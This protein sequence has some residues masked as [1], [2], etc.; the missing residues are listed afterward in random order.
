MKKNDRTAEPEALVKVLLFSGHQISRSI[1]SN[2]EEDKLVAGLIP[3]PAEID[4][5]LRFILTE[6]SFRK[7]AHKF[8]D[9]EIQE[10]EN[11]GHYLSE[12]LKHLNLVLQEMIRREILI[13]T[14]QDQAEVKKTMDAFCRGVAEHISIV[15]TFKDTIP[16]LK[17][18]KWLDL[19]RRYFNQ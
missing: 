7:L 4:Q 14:M 16:G 8:S 17:V 19:Q 12:L 1:I 3:P 11:M 15:W 13:A 2:S 5:D 10:I 6:Q 18:A 9:A